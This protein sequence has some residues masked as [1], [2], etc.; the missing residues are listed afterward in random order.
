VARPKKSQFDKLVVNNRLAN[1]YAKSFDQYRKRLDELDR[2]VFQNMTLGEQ[3]PKALFKVLANAAQ[4]LHDA[5]VVLEGAEPVGIVRK[6]A[7]DLCGAIR[8]VVQT[9]GGIT[10][11]ASPG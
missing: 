3:P 10:P 2:E 5:L 7:A 6:P 9:L 11:N 1:S 8:R 4:D